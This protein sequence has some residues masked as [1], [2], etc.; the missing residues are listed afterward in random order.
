[1]QHR[2][3]ELP[4]HQ[5]LY[6]RYQ[7]QSQIPWMLGGA[8][9]PSLSVPSNS[10]A[11]LHKPLRSRRQSLDKVPCAYEEEGRNNRFGSATFWVSWCPGNRRIPLNLSCAKFLTAAL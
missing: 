7:D 11:M 2:A 9:P 10:I 1:M 4:H 3:A 6:K 8:S 5:I